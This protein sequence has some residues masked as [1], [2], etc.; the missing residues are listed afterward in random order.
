MLGMV[1]RDPSDVVVPDGL[2]GQG[3]ARGFLLGGKGAQGTENENESAAQ[4]RFPKGRD[5][6]PSVE[7]D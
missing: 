7:S 1:R 5:H 4:G 3:A 6:K 2:P